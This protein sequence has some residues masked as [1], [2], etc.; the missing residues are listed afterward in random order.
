MSAPPFT[1]FAMQG[2]REGP[3]LTVY[4]EGDGL[5]W[6]SR[7]RPSSDPTP[8]DPVALRMALADP[9]GTVL[10]LARPCQYLASGAGNA[11]STRHWTSHRF[12]A[13]VVEAYVAAINAYAE[14][15]NFQ[16]VLLVGY[17]GGGVL[18]TLVAQRLPSVKGLITAAAPV[19]HRTWTRHHDVSLLSGSVDPMAKMNNLRKLPQVHFVGTEDEIVPAVVQHAFRAQVEKIAPAKFWTVAGFSHTCC[20]AEQWPTLIAKARAQIGRAAKG[21]SGIRP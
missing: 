8:D 18:A 21:L 6:I 1:L 11:C 7:S 20:W 14:Q 2:P 15:R 4:L 10:Y 5:A 16:S 19:D 3:S 9:E 13:E 12:S 17:S